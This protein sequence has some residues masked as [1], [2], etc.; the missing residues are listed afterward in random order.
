M[1]TSV[2]Q[3][4]TDA[5]V[6]GLQLIVVYS[7]YG[8][9][10]E[11]IRRLKEMS[12]TSIARRECSPNNPSQIAQLDADALVEAL[13]Q[14]LKRQLS[15]VKTLIALNQCFKARRLRLPKLKMCTL[16]SGI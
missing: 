15:I 5:V 2:Y 9:L 3:R 10:Q 11:H 4:A 6:L 8:L 16:F 12:V 1:L 14:T 7:V 13:E